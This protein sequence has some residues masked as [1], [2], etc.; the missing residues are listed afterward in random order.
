MS[1]VSG[2]HLWLGAG[3]MLEYGLE[4]AQ[5][6]LVG[7]PPRGGGV[8][9]GLVGAGKGQRFSGGGRGEEWM[10]DADRRGQGTAPLPPAATCYALALATPPAC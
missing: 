5:R 3:V 1:D 9:W 6:L 10:E 7:D 4:D 8:G 2:V